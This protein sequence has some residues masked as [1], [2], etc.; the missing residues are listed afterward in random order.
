VKRS[1]ATTAPPSGRPSDEA[2][3]EAYLILEPG[4]RRCYEE[5]FARRI[6]QRPF[7]LCL[8]SGFDSSGKLEY[9]NFSTTQVILPED[10]QA[11]LK[12]LRTSFAP[13]GLREIS[14]VQPFRLSTR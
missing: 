5:K 10:F 2:V 3:R 7:H 8:V 13:K 11:C 4:V 1:A 12:A 14:V 6:A 9:F